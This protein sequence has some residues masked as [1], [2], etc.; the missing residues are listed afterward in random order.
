M[1][2]GLHY[3]LWSTFGHGDKISSVLYLLGLPVAGVAIYKT[4]RWSYP[5]YLFIASAM[6]IS[7]YLTWLRFPQYFGLGPLILSYLVNLGVVSYFLIPAVRNVYFN[8]RVRW[9]ESK[10]RYDV[11]IPSHAKMGEIDSFGTIQN[12]SEG[13]LFVQ[14][15]AILL[16]GN[17]IEITFAC[18]GKQYKVPGKVVYPRHAPPPGYGVQFQLTPEVAHE[19]KDCIK[20]LKHSGAHERTGNSNPWQEFKSWFVTVVSTGKGLVPSTGPSSQPK[21]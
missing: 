20:T 2:A 14:T 11:E 4:N 9:W 7:N 10:P 18:N 8:P 1:N 19:M 13:G 17:E 6:L 3:Y 15:D 12:I 5:I 21:M 16:A